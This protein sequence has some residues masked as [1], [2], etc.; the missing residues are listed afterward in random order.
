MQ[1]LVSLSIAE[2]FNLLTYNFDLDLQNL[3]IKLE[4]KYKLLSYF[5][6]TLKLLNITSLKLNN[7]VIFKKKWKFGTIITEIKNNYE[8]FKII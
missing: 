4:M 2:S 3:G 1:T 5:A 8:K 6:S 7:L